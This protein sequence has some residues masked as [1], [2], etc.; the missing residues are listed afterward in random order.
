M[1]SRLLAILALSQSSFVFSLDDI[2]LTYETA[3]LTVQADLLAQKNLLLGSNDTI[4]ECHLSESD[5]NL[6]D[7]SDDHTTLI[8]TG[9]KTQCI[10]EDST[11][12]SFQVVRGDPKKVL[13]YFQG[14]GAC[15]N[16]PST[17]LGLCSTD[18]IASP[19]YGIFNRDPTKN[20]DYYDHTFIQVLYCSGD[21]HA[22]NSTRPYDEHGTNNSV[23]QVGA[24]NT[25][26][27][28]DWLADQ[29]LGVLDELIVGGTSA[30][31][32]G[33]Q[34]WAD[35]IVSTVPS[36]NTAM[37]FDSFVGVLPPTSEGPLIKEFGLCDSVILD[38]WPELEAKCNADELTLQDMVTNAMA[39]HPDQTFAHI[40]SKTDW[41]QQA[42]Y[43]LIGAFNMSLDAHITPS[44]YYQKVNYVFEGYHTYPNHVAFLVDAS[45]HV[46]TNSPLYFSADTNSMSG[47]DGLSE[48]LYNWVGSMPLGNNDG[49]GDSN[50]TWACAGDRMT[51]DE[52]EATDPK[53]HSY[54]DSALT[55]RVIYAP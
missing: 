2:P 1:R 38:A 26:A 31:S 46:Y 29:N 5:C 44:E 35:W 45:K 21:V 17:R 10:Y 28:L 55:D 23:V 53:P 36:S 43:I 39:A 12:Y 6:S 54:C 34:V 30:G 49:H 47:S 18:A 48:K 4:D 11:P 50:L 40:N 25:L 42:Y 22:G 27:V 19:L 15:W 51:M 24:V 20:P 32:L 13:F 52:V 14:G 41:V 9:G 7:L 37:L 8:Y 3:L 16:K 33:A